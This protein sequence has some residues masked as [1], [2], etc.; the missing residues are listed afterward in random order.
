MGGENR[1]ERSTEAETLLSCWPWLTLLP[2]PVPA[3]WAALCGSMAAASAASGS[4]SRHRGSMAA[5]SAA[6]GS[7]FRHRGPMAAVSAVSDLSY[8]HRGSMTA[9]SAVSD[10]SYR[11]RG[12]MAA[13]KSL[14]WAGCVWL[15]QMHPRPRLGPRD[16]V[17][18][19]L[20]SH[21]SPQHL[22]D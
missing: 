15:L 1:I 11:H 5:A 21:Q 14:A 17:R 13:A 18:H 20:H 8:R 19:R 2:V 12:S 16:H 9:A 3:C 10:L 7:H 6:S 22:L 4:H